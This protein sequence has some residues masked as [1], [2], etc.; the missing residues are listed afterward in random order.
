MRIDVLFVSRLKR[1]LVGHWPDWLS[2]A[3]VL[4]AVSGL[5]TAEPVRP[6]LDILMAAGACRVG[7]SGS[8]SESRGQIYKES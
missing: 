5:N 6:V 3:I 7:H 1:V 2:S 8:R 4:A